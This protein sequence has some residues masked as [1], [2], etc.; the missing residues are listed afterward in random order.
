MPPGLSGGLLGLAEAPA[1]RRLSAQ[2]GASSLSHLA[3]RMLH[4]I[5][6]FLACGKDSI[7]QHCVKRHLAACGCLY[8]CFRGAG[9]RH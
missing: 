6:S 5:T 1:C 9:A 8:T 4:W 2:A 3:D 7:P